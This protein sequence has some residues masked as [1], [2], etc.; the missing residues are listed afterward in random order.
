[1]SIKHA[2]HQDP[3]S[4]ALNLGEPKKSTIIDSDY[5]STKAD[6]DDNDAE[7]DS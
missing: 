4:I 1:M 7:N 5:D 3:S 2:G 6:R